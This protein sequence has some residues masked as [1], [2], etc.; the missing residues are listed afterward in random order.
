M[1]SVDEAL[2]IVIEAAHALP[3]SVIPITD[4]VGFVLSEDI[5]SEENVPSFDNSAMDGYAVRSVDVQSA[6]REN[7]IALAVIDLIQAGDVS[8]HH[9]E[10]GQAI[11]IM[12]G[13]PMPLGADAVVMIEAT[14]KTND[15]S[16]LIFSPVG[17]D[18]NRR[19]AGDDIRA[20]HIVFQKDRLIKPYDIGVLASIGKIAASVYPKPK[21]AIISTGNELV[22]INEPLPL[23][24][25]RSSNNFTLQAL[26]R[27][28][29]A[30]VIDLG[31]AKDSLSETEQKLQ[32]AFSA[33]IVL[34]S[35][36]VSMGEFDF[37]RLALEKLGVAIKFW[38]VKQRPGKPLVFGTYQEK[39]FFGL[40]GN[41]VSSAVCFELFVVPA[42][43]KMSGISNLQ[44]LRIKAKS[45]E[46]ILK[47]PGLRYFLRGMVGK[48]NTEF[49]V[50]LT[51][52]QSSGVLSSLSYA[53]C[54]ID[55]PE[56]QG[57]TKIGDQ[58]TTVI[59][60]PDT[61]NDLFCS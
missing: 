48:H 5:I 15:R 42:I 20:G 56:E 36:G 52:N 33:D 21:I 55:I 17:K 45:T 2:R 44:P 59:L 14:E 61:F 18:E 47:K 22:G 35:G 43:K 3:P 51:G 4:S 57:D 58:V 29:G 27:A 26:I 60:N 8:Q 24:K 7:P 19:H 12:T 23:G 28:M 34:T 6:S 49:V 30:E 10:K 32:K 54:L 40:P 13:A 41:P 38:K 53:N 11:Q 39:L 31:I 50:S 37:V 1:V 25:I 16:V 46:T 9:L